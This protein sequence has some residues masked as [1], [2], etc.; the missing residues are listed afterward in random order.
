MEFNFDLDIRW[1]KGGQIVTVQNPIYVTEEPIIVP[2]G[3]R[4]DGASIPKFLHWFAR[5]FGEALYAAIVHDYCYASHCLPRDWA[6][7][8]FLKHLIKTGM[9]PYK[10]WVMW[11][12]VRLFGKQA[13]YRNKK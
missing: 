12:A 6:D 9:N 7:S 10:A 11:A 2:V 8:L 1:E 3:F 13:Y 5:P 4:S